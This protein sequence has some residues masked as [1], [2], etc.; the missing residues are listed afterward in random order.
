MENRAAEMEVFATVVE[1]GNFSAAAR[2]LGMT[3]SAV[4][5]MISRLEARLGVPLAV[6]N[7]RSFR[8]TAEGESYLSRAQEILADMDRVEAVIRQSSGHIGG[9]LR[10]SSNIPFAIH[11][12]APVL[13]RFL[14]NYPDVRVDLE[15]S[16]EQVDLIFDRTDIAIRSGELADSSMIARKLLSSRRFIVASPDYIAHH[17]QPGH[18]QDLAGHNC[19]GLSGRRWFSQWPFLMPDGRAE[20]IEV[21]GNLFFNNGESLRQFAL[22]GVGIARLSE[23]HVGEDLAAGRLV[24]LLESFNPGDVEPINAIYSSQSHVPLRIR[25]F[26]DFLLVDLTSVGKAHK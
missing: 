3:P 17:G 16:D 4:S 22:R 6:R 7:T 9:L 10:I 5:K 25:A 23:F 24:P 13:I 2:S 11:K 8:L 26:I 15:H 19:L 1:Q 20:R 12:L 18:P 14:A 21:G